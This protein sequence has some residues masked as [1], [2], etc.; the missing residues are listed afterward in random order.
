MPEIVEDGVTGFLV[1]SIEAMSRA[2][3][4]AA[5]LDP[6]ACRAAAEAR[7]AAQPMLEAY[8]RLYEQLAARELI[9][10]VMDM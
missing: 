8:A 6:Q 10:G 9:S 7:F 2:M 1:T 4:D 3:R 5:A